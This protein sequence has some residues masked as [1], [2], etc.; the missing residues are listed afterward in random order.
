M[1][2]VGY[3]NKKLDR[4]ISNVIDKLFNEN[5]TLIFI[6][7]NLTEVELPD[8]IKTGY[9]VARSNSPTHLAFEKP[10]SFIIHLSY[11]SRST[12]LII[13]N[14]RGTSKLSNI[15][16][17]VWEFNLQKLVVLTYFVEDDVFVRVHTSDPLHKENE[18][19]TKAKIIKSVNYS[20]NL[21]IVLTT[22]QFEPGITNVEELAAA[23]ITLYANHYYYN[24]FYMS[25]KDVDSLYNVI[26]N[27]IKF[28][29]QMNYKDYT[30]LLKSGDNGLF[31]SELEIRYL[32]YLMGHELRI[33]VIDTGTIIRKQNPCFIFYPDGYLK[34]SLNLFI[35]PME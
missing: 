17:D 27:K 32:R 3:L 31:V 12:Y 21:S 34:K 1:Q 23:D 7:D 26:K 19:A 30:D 18:C 5:D 9:A 6:Y 28:V 11:G 29:H 8:V 24:Y 35:Q 2:R 13:V 22:P 33:N 10:N 25:D 16:E 4:I 15:F 14:E 20:E